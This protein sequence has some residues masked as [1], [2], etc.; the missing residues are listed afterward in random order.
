MSAHTIR[1]VTRDEFVELGTALYVGRVPVPTNQTATML[2]G[3][4]IGL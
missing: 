1:R 3:A 4:D 2:E